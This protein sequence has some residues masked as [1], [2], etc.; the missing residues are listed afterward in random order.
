[1]QKQLQQNIVPILEA[2]KIG[3]EKHGEEFM[4][5]RFE[6]SAKRL[7]KNIFLCGLYDNAYLDPK[8]S[9][10]VA[11]CKEFCDKGFEAQAGTSEKTLQTAAMPEKSELQEMNPT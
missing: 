1:M 11:G 10:Q 7:L 8:V 9:K 4:K 6:Q 5:K 3:C 2:Y